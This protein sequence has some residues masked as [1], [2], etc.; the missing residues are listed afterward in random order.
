MDQLCRE[1]R[2]RAKEMV[3]VV[4]WENIGGGGRVGEDSFW[5][6][7]AEREADL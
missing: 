1:G 3:V 4:V 2:E 6:R 5:T 7:S